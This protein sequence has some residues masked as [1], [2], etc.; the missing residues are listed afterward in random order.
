MHQ[1]DPVEL[2]QPT[3]EVACR[4]AESALDVRDEDNCLVGALGRECLSLRRSPP[5]LRLRSQH[6]TVDQ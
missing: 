3:Q 5:D 4:D 2:Q 1:L 6:P